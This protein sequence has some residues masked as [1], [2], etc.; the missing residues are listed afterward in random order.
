MAFPVEQQTVRARRTP[1]K[2]GPQTLQRPI[3]P[4]WTAY[5]GSGRPGTVHP[6]VD[7]AG[8]ANTAQQSHSA[9]LSV[10][11]RGNVGMQVEEGAENT[12]G[13][14]QQESGMAVSNIVRFG[15]N[16]V[17]QSSGTH[18]GLSVS[19]IAPVSGRTRTNEMENLENFYE[20]ESF[21]K[22]FRIHP[23]KVTLLF[24]SLVKRVDLEWSRLKWKTLDPQSS[25]QE[26]SEA[27]MGLGV[28]KQI[29]R[30][31]KQDSFNLGAQLLSQY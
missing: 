3:K 2:E 8:G 13:P 18:G 30:G 6:P 10:S 26:I 14:A 4:R 27:K 9:S 19:P 16:F 21:D 20:Y 31:F 1:L 22:N 17:G 15:E 11:T 23:E 28:L 12:I 24:E 29:I 7:D 5:P 25:A